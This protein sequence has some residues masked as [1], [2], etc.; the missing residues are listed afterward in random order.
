MSG[1]YFDYIQYRFDD[2]LEKINE[3]I[4]NNNNENVDDFDDKYG[5]HYSPET[6]E[7]FEFA[8]NA[9]RNAQTYIQRIDWL[10]SCD[11]SEESFHRRLQ[12]DL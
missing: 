8:K 5:R 6:I 9:I 4:V 12:E 7:K 1:G 10:V 2:V 11:D 3:L